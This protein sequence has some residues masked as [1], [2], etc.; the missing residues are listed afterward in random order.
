MRRAGRLRR[1]CSAFPRPR[2]EPAAW[3][4]CTARPSARVG[5]VVVHAAAPRGPGAPAAGQGRCSTVIGRRCQELR[6][7][8]AGATWRIVYR[9]DADAIVIAEVFAKQTRATPKAVIT[10]CRRRLTA[11]D[12]LMDAKE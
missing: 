11:Y 7:V 3:P 8:D 5:V 2:G 9:T 4:A 6:I 12:A 1:R 10:A